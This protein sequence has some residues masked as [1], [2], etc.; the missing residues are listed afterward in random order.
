VFKMPHLR[1]WALAGGYAFLPAIGRHE[2]LV[3]DTQRWT[4]VARVPVHGQP[5]FVV[6]QP[7]GR[8]V[9]VNFAFPR[10]D[11]VQVIDVP[12]MKT[13]ADLRPGR[14]VLHLEFTPRGEQ[15]WVSSRDD[16]AVVVYDTAS[17]AERTRL[18]AE[19]PS[20]IFL[21]SRAAATGF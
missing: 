1:G 7:G 10:N 11:V 4:E 5:V 13:I 20:G 21:T 9:W 17:L 18:P 15:V 16:N 2:V 14:A 19:R 8:R 3:V 12:A 6:A